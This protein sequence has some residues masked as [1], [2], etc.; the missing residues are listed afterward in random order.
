MSARSNPLSTRADRLADRHRDEVL[1]AE[2]EV[3]GE[4]G[5]PGADDGH[6]PHRVTPA[7]HRRERVA[8]V[9]NPGSHCDAA[10]D[11]RSRI[12]D[13]DRTRR[14][15]GHPREQTYAGVAELDDHDGVRRREAGHG[16]VHGGG[17]VNGRVARKGDELGVALG[18][19]AQAPV[20]RRQG[21]RGAVR[22]PTGLEAH[23]GVE[24]A[25]V[26]G[27]RDPDLG[28]G[29]RARRHRDLRVGLDPLHA[30]RPDV[31]LRRGHRRLLEG[32]HESDRAAFGQ[33]G[34]REERRARPG[35]GHA[36]CAAFAER[37]RVR[38]R[39]GRPR[40]RPCR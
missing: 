29:R 35:R 3:L 4:G 10:E 37:S 32:E 8:V 11:H 12:A 7:A 9:G 39:R 18:A 22:A 36:R 26:G 2:V 30:R 20:T 28:S 33:V 25:V 24:G 6:P 14:H 31:E 5:H 27:E 40:R 17:R 23:L 15:A 16:S 34:E 1:D 13:A 19:A 21:E 38:V